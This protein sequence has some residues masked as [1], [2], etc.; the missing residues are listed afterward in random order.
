MTKI[1]L[2]PLFKNIL[3]TCHS[4][5]ANEI[6][7]LDGNEIVDIPFNYIDLSNRNDILTF[8]PSER[9]EEILANYKY[10]IARGGHLFKAVIKM[11]KLGFKSVE[12]KEK[13]PHGTEVRVKQLVMSKKDKSRDVAWVETESG[14]ERL[15]YYDKLSRV[16]EDPFKLC[17]NQVRAGRIFNHLLTGKTYT[18]HELE[19]LVNQWKSGYDIYKSKYANLDVVNGELIHHWYNSENYESRNGTLGGSCMAGAPRTQLSLYVENPESVQLLIMYSTNESK[20]KE[21]KLVSNKIKGRALVWKLVDG[22]YF[23]DRIYTNDDADSNIFRTY[24]EEMGWVTFT[25]RGCL[26]RGSL[27][28]QMKNVAFETLP[29]LDTMHNVD[30]QTNRVSNQRL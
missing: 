11:R 16:Q 15:Y 29:Y 13:L 12:Q 28:V 20:T 9:V 5:L 25:Q 3:S 6:I 30:R 14:E 7:S 4:R 10:F 18:T 26:D 8:T 23:M 1:V 22:R 24:A 21:G 19:E 17:R 2:S 27:V